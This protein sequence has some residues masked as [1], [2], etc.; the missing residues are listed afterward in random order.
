MLGTPVPWGILAVVKISRLSAGSE[1]LCDL[2]SSH[3]RNK[4]HN[5]SFQADNPMHTVD[6]IEDKG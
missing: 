2:F 4:S 6:G 1:G 5:P 3:E